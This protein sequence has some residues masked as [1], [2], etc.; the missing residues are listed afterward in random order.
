LTN[1]NGPTPSVLIAIVNYRTGGLVVD[2]LASLAAEIEANPGTR[3]VVV[4]NASG[5]CSCE[6]IATA[7]KERGWSSWAKLVVSPVNGGFADGNNRAIAA[8]MNSGA[9]RDFVW[10][11][12]PDT[13]VRPGAVRTMTEFMRAH[14]RAGIVGTLLEERDGTPWPYAFRFPN[15]LG[16]IERGARLG[17]VSRLLRDHAIPV[18][19]G[20][21]PTQVDWVSGASMLIRATVFDEIG[22]MDSRYFLYYEETDFCLQARK[23]GWECWYVPDARV[24]HIA[25]QS[26][27]LTGR[28][29][30]VRRMPRYWFESRHRYFVKNHGRLYAM[31]ADILW[32]AGH[33]AWRLRRRLQSLADPDPPKLLSDFLRHSALLHGPTPRKRNTA[34]NR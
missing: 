19:M 28:Q 33:M 17:A 7:I 27:G 30:V 5:G 1:Q 16:E 15:M 18:R 26:T 31:A 6:R 14:P 9:A 20:N 24:L 21:Q 22:P 32:I 11:L 3:A 34:S 8:D 23:A 2:C 13:L 12:N 4:D 10:L 25:G 29:A